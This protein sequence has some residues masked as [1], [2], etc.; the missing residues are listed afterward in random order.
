LLSLA[1]LDHGLCITERRTGAVIL[2]AV[3]LSA[4]FLSAVFLSAVTV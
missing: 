1:R 3:F 4:V 2:S